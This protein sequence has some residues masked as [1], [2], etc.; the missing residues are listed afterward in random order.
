MARRETRAKLKDEK[1]KVKALKVS[2]FDRFPFDFQRSSSFSID[3]HRFFPLT[4][5]MTFETF[6]PLVEADEGSLGLPVRLPS[7]HVLRHGRYQSVGDP[8]QPTQLRHEAEVATHSWP[9]EEDAR[10]QRHLPTMRPSCEPP[11]VGLN[12]R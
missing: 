1:L 11:R 8:T 4:F 2:D 5:S 6:R 9:L 12:G 10:G 7:E 3:V